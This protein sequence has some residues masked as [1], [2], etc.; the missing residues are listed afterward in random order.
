[1]TDK[2]RIDRLERLVIDLSLALRRWT[3]ETDGHWGHP[4]TA[5]EFDRVADELSR[6]AEPKGEG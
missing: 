4:R 3:S 2:E 1:M 6:P 5:A